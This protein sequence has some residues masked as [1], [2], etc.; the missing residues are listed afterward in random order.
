[1]STQA[2]WRW[3][4]KGI[5]LPDGRVV[6]LETLKL[7]GRYMTSIEALERFIAAQNEPVTNPPVFDDIRSRSARERQSDRAAEFLTEKG[8]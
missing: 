5:K 4:V 1:L 2:V 8:I 7:A 6:K 3:A